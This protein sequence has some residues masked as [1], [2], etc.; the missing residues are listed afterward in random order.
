MVAQSDQRRATRHQQ[1]ALSPLFGAA[2]LSYQVGFTII[3]VVVAVVSPVY[4]LALL[5][6]VISSQSRRVAFGCALIFVIGIF[7]I[8]NL[9]RT[10]TSDWLWYTRH[11][12]YILDNGVQ[13]YFGLASH[14]YN[15]LSSL[16][17][18]APRLTEPM[19][20]VFC[21]VVGN[22]SGGSVAAL[23]VAVTVAIYLPIALVCFAIASRY[24]RD[25][26][27]LY[28]VVVGACCIGVVFTLTNHLVR[29]ELAM[30]LLFPFAYL[31]LM[32]RFIA[33]A[34][35]ALLSILT[36]NSAAVIA[37]MIVAASVSIRLPSRLQLPALL[38]AC[39]IIAIG[40][41]MLLGSERIDSFH[42]DGSV[43]TSVYV[44]DAAILLA[45][46]YLRRQR[47][48]DPDFASFILALAALM[49][50]FLI[51]AY[52]VKLLF[53]RMYFY[54]DLVRTLC[55]VVVLSSLLRNWRGSYLP[56]CAVLVLALAYVDMRIGNSPFIY[57]STLISPWTNF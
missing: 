33:S 1:G 56:R 16:Y 43:S 31:L 21:A 2:G 10:P 20:Y 22:L 57:A 38:A 54:M 34:P 8:Y 27:I 45:T 28:T 19:F 44:L 6:M 13:R 7:V 39:L 46:L 3:L 17:G 9:Q 41:L 55:L 48:A 12:K 15:D 11:Y 37:V 35:F 18:I 53:L 36:H 4:S 52:P 50:V 49:L 29:Q 47:H 23:N 42:D 40:A 51:V 14:E 24:T 30:S 26:A 5:L 25:P 32:R